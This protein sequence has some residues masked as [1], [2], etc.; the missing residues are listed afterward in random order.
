METHFPLL[1]PV[2]PIYFLSSLL[3][4]PSHPSCSGLDS[5]FKLPLTSLSPSQS[6]VVVGRATGRKAFR[7]RKLDAALCLSDA[8]LEFSARV[9]EWGAVLLLRRSL[10]LESRV[11]SLDAWLNLHSAL[12]LLS[13]PASEGQTTRVKS[14]RG[15]V[16]SDLPF[17]PLCASHLYRNVSQCLLVLSDLIV[18]S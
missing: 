9:F 12:Y 4:L 2:E 14:R 10:H 7:N 15:I 6:H 3:F 8:F 5:S 1:L 11:L 17:G 16:R 18:S 13:G